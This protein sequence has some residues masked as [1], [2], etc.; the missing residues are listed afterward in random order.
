[1][2]KK[3]FFWISL[4]VFFAVVAW[5]ISDIYHVSQQQKVKVPDLPVIKNYNLESNILDQ[6]GKKN[7]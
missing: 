1:M 5:L 6:L 7:P 4:T 3:E 2:N